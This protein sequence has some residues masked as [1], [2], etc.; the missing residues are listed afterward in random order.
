MAVVLVGAGTALGLLLRGPGAQAVGGRPPPPPTS[1]TASSTSCNFTPEIRN[2]P[3]LCVNQ[4][5]G[6]SDTA[7]V[8]HGDG[9]DPGSTISISIAGVGVS[10]YHP[11]ADQMGTFNYAIDQGHYFFSGTI[12]AGDYHVVATDTSGRTARVSFLVNLPGSGPP[13][14]G[15]PPS[16]LP[17]PS[18]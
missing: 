2:T 12:P 6:D 18:S 4:P 8:I 17:P 9:F 5:F 16:G 3:T 1:I 11:V 13:G 14:Q 10:R 7:F 15:P